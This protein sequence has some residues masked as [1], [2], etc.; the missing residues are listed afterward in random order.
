[1]KNSNLTIIEL[2]QTDGGTLKRLASTNGGEY[3][4]PC[5]WCGG[6]DRFRVW[7]GSG[8]YWCR[9]CGKS[10]DTIQYLIDRHGFTYKEACH[11]L[12]IMAALKKYGSKSARPAKPDYTP[13]ETQTPVDVWQSK[14][15]SF[16]DG[17]IGD[18]WSSAG[19]SIC[20]WLRDKKGL[21]DETIKKAMLGYSQKD[22][23]E[24]RE[25]WG[26]ETALKED[27]TQRRQWIPAGLVIPFVKNDK[28]VRLRI[29]R[30]KKNIDK[31][32]IIVSGSSTTPLIIGHN[33]GAAVIVE[34]ELDAILLSQE[35]GDLITTIAMGNAT[36]KP[37]I[38][39][40]AIF[41]TVPVILNCLDT[42]DAGAKAAW[43]FWPE[44]YG[45]KVKRWPT[46]KGKD[47]SEARLNGVD[48]RTWIIAGLFQNE[49]NY[50]RF[51]IQTVDGGLSDTKAIKNL[52]SE[53][54]SSWGHE[55]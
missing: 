45:D 10:G 9:N 27:G 1:M 17:A 44:T 43:K 32:Y 37:D 52:F 8:R 31:R 49:V 19:E 5:F 29:R 54:I 51:C 42:D 13:K 18:L 41:K 22:I 2:I 4:G 33:N 48:L 38:E 25:S 3:A 14:A 55:K 53:K 24:P 47:A 7:P 50:E 6:N 40:D 39:T 46:I 28:I 15:K 20:Q 30:D 36:A 21:N 23:Y 12:G 11:K 16:L 35:T 34:S 26:L